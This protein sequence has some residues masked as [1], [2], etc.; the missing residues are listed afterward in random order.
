MIYKVDEVDGC[1]TYA[2]EGK[3]MLCSDG[4]RMKK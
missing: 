3:R 1:G 2:E 4:R